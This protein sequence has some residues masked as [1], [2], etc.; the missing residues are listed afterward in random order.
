MEISWEN[1]NLD[2][3]AYM[4]NVFFQGQSVQHGN[5][6][7]VINNLQDSLSTF[8]PSLKVLQSNRI[9]ACDSF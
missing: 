9:F 3:G 1:L 6:F 2:I 7:S 8:S 5:Q 4:V